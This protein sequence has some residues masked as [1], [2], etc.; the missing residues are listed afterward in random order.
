[1]T[2]RPHRYGCAAVAALLIATA[3]TLA[4]RTAAAQWSTTFEQHY[5]ADGSNWA[6]R[7]NY[8]AAD[9]L[10]NAFDYG[11][12]ILYE[13]SIRDRRRSVDGWSRRSTTSSRRS[14]S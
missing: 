6:F 9:R 8:P 7:K 11:H 3:T 12:A 13:R 4:P 14:C 2:T 10:F 1:M 5:L